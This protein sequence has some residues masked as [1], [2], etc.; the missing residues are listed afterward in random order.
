MPTMRKEDWVKKLSVHGV[1]EG[2]SVTQLKTHWAEGRSMGPGQKTEKELRSQ[3]LK[4]AAKKKNLLT[5]FLKKEGLTQESNATIAQMFNRGEQKILQ[6]TS[7]RRRKWR[8]LG[9]MGT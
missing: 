7:L 8:G 6:I 2:W 1:P 3:G 9:N 4:V 5:D